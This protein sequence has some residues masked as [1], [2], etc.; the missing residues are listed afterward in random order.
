MTPMVSN[1]RSR[2]PF[3]GL[4]AASIAISSVLAVP[5]PLDST[6][7]RPTS[8]DS[9]VFCVDAKSAA[10]KNTSECVSNRTLALG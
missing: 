1:A 2:R 4:P 6:Q 3:C 9:G 10:T 5:S 7:W 8:T